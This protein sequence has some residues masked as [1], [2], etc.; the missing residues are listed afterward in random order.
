MAAISDKMQD[1]LNGQVT[2]EM[3][4]TNLY[5]AMS[6]YFESLDLAGF[7]HWMRVQAKEEDL[8]VQKLFDYITERGGRVVIGAVK[9]PP[10]EW[11]SPL[12]AFESTLEHE[13]E[14][15]AKVFK[16]VEVAQQ[17]GDRF[18]ESFLRW[19]VDE[20]VEE[21]ASV[22]RVVKSVRLGDGQPVAMLML[23]RELA[24]RPAAPAVPAPAG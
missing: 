2:A 3:Y 4:S 7:A 12:E 11:G 20:Q 21:E 18:T 5:L 1:A 14:V 17:E 16:L 9:A 24:T 8:H 23:D 22:D 13:Q 6:A 10:V 19:F 15:S